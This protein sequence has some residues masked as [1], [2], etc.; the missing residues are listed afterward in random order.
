MKLKDEQDLIE[1][2]LLVRSVSPEAYRGLVNA[3]R[4]HGL[5]AMQKTV[6]APAEHVLHFQGRAREA[7]EISDIVESAADL[8]QKLKAGTP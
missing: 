6:I 8:L 3:L 7:L 1:A 2:A 4:S 5:R